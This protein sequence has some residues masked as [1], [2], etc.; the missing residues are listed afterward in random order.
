MAK[1][2]QSETEKEYQKERQRIIKL[3]EQGS[4]RGFIFPEDVVPEIPKTITHKEVE[5]LKRVTKQSLYQTAKFIDTSTGEII[6]PLRRTSIPKQESESRTKKP[7]V[8]QTNIQITTPHIPKTPKPKANKPKQKQEQ[9]IDDSGLTRGQKAWQ[10]RRANMTDEEYEAYRKE[11][12]D[13]MKQAREAKGITVTPTENYPTISAIDKVSEKLDELEKFITPNIDYV[14]FSV[15]TL[16]RDSETDM[17]VPIPIEARKSALINVWEDTVVN[18][19][20][21]PQPLEDYLIANMDDIDT[22]FDVIRYSWYPE[23]VETSFVTLGRILNQGPLSPMQAE[24]LSYMSEFNMA[25]E[26]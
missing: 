25:T 11:F 20:D 26:W 13:R 21:N 22:Q 10:T 17:K 5:Q 19:E 16:E 9:S 24:G 4:K 1:R 18:N 3:I 8:P 12:A 2:V 14:D 7:Q 6:E 23:A 15:R